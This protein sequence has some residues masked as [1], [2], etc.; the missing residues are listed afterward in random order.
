MQLKGKGSVNAPKFSIAKLKSKFPRFIGKKEKALQKTLINFPVGCDLKHLE[1]N[2]I[3][4]TAKEEMYCIAGNVDVKAF[5][6]ISKAV[7][8]DL[9]T[10]V[11]EK[12]HTSLLNL[13]SENVKLRSSQI[14]KRNFS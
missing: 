12:S 14:K 4:F 13:V 11:N 8:N 1:I 10:L 6:F 5:N 7:F 9:K 3:R 2:H